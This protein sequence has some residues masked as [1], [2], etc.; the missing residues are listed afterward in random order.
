MIFSGAEDELFSGNWMNSTA[1]DIMAPNNAKSPS[2]VDNEDVVGAAP[3][4]HGMD[5]W[6]KSGHYFLRGQV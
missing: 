5:C 4:V 6:G 1:A 2:V 3:T